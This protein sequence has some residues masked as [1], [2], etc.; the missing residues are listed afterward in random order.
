MSR[1]APKKLII[2]GLLLIAATNAIVLA[3]V[4]YNRS[5]SPT[6]IVVLSERE[7]NLPYRYSRNKENSGI[8]LKLKWRVL[9]DAI[10]GQRYSSYNYGR[11][12]W[13]DEEKLRSIGFKFEQKPGDK[14][15]YSYY[16]RLLPREA[17]LVL[18]YHGK[19]YDEALKKAKAH[20]GKEEALL[21]RNPKKEEFIKRVK[22]AKEI[23]ND[24]KLIRSR[25]FVVDAGLGYNE[26]RA[27]YPNKARY[28]ITPGKIRATIDRRK[29]KDVV[30]GHISNLSVGQ[31]QVPLE[32]RQVLAPLLK[33]SRNRRDKVAPRYSVRLAYGKRMEPW[34]VDVT[35]FE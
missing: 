18:E 13:L 24:E 16:R 28:I 1:F 35:I 7:A 33:K 34:V 23:V 31:I 26:L 12:V 21:R 20:L 22:E 29:K 25:L 32:G 6:Y 3:G 19:A 17:M 9:G 4:A 14:G 5:E 2:T 8:A 27:K 10:A 11:P 30:S 15:A